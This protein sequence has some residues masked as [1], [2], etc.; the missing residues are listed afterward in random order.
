MN[1]NKKKRVVKDLSGT[2]WFVT[3]TG[4][5]FPTNWRRQALVLNYQEKKK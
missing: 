1:K 2:R 5:V 3:K 4:K